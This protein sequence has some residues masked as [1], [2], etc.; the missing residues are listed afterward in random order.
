MENL[1]DAL[2]EADWAKIAR[3]DEQMKND[4]LQGRNQDLDILRG[5]MRIKQ[6]LIS[7]QGLTI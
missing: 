5:K 7:L 2:V 3:D 1:I 6:M 4:K